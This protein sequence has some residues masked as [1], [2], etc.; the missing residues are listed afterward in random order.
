MPDFDAA[1][2]NALIANRRYEEAKALLRQSTDA[3]AKRWLSNLEW[4]FPEQTPQ[5]TTASVYRSRP[6]PNPLKNVPLVVAIPVA[7][8]GIFIGERLSAAGANPLV[9]LLVIWGLLFGVPLS[10]VA[11]RKITGHQYPGGSNTR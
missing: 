7:I 8:L 10:I 5:L 6:N 1:H 11:F 3:T 9:V 4:Q 2:I